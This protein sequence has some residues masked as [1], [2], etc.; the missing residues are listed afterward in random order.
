VPDPHIPHVKPDS[1]FQALAAENG[2]PLTVR[3][4]SPDE[5]AALRARRDHDV[6]MRGMQ[7]RPPSPKNFARKSLE[8]WAKVREELL[9]ETAGDDN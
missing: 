6:A 4:A 8:R 2:K 7:R 9:N 5:L 1:Y 3:Q